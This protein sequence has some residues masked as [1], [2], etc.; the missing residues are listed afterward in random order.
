MTGDKTQMNSNEQFEQVG[1]RPAK[2]EQTVPEQP[3]PL[4]EQGK[5]RA[6]AQTSQ[7]ASPGRRPLFRT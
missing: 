7:R 3:K 4:T 5:V 2:S 1:R 6:A